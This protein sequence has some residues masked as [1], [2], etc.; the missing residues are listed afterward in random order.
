M[1]NLDDVVILI[2]RI[3]ISGFLPLLKCKDGGIKNCNKLFKML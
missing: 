1:P 2:E 3:L